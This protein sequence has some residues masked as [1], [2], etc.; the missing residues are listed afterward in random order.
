VEEGI[1]DFYTAPIFD[2]GTGPNPIQ[3]V[4][5]CRPN[6]LLKISYP[7][8]IRMRPISISPFKENGPPPMAC[9]FL[10]FF[11][12]MACFKYTSMFFEN[13]YLKK[14]KKTHQEFASSSRFM[15]CGCRTLSLWNC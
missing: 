2:S 11:S 7:I 9:F 12:S 8:C 3:P 6:L 1:K 5:I 4:H 13:K 10:F 15:D 14:K